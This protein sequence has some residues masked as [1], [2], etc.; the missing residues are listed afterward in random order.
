MSDRR[1]L[2]EVFFSMCGIETPNGVKSAFCICGIVGTK[3]RAEKVILEED[4]NM[5]STECLISRW[6]E[7]IGIRWDT[8]KG[9]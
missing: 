6:K 1:R 4:I 8:L 9:E 2:N 7:K 3:R 5:D